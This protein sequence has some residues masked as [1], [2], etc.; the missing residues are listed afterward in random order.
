MERGGIQ[1]GSLEEEDAEDRA[2]AEHHKGASGGASQRPEPVFSIEGGATY[3]VLSLGVLPET[4]LEV[5]RDWSS[6]CCR[7]GVALRRLVLGSAFSYVYV[8]AVSCRLGLINEY[9]YIGEVG[10]PETFR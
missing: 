2:Q 5:D 4:A 9:A 10:W 1:R 8:C 7:R 3:R 6:S